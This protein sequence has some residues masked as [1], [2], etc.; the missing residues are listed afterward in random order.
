ML[1]THYLEMYTAQPTL[2]SYYSSI[3]HRKR[4]GLDYSGHSIDTS[5]DDL[6]V[7]LQNEES[8]HGEGSD[9]SYG[10]RGYCERYYIYEYY[11]RCLMHTAFLHQSPRTGSLLLATTDLSHP[12]AGF[13]ATGEAGHARRAG[14][15]HP[16]GVSPLEAR[17]D[18]MR[19]M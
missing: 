17:C 1:R 10:L 19:Q 14:E 11:P 4:Q 15:D 6:A 13:E 2:P 3:S 8:K 7:H 5:I 9:S 12:G 16:A 18:P